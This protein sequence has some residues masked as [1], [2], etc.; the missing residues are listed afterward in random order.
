MKNFTNDDYIN[1]NKLTCSGYKIYNPGFVNNFLLVEARLSK[2]ILK[3]INFFNI[4]EK[5]ELLS[6]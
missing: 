6:T 3:Q 4:F 5:E 1:S 2:Y